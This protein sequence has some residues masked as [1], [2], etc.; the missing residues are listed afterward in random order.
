MINIY[1]KNNPF[2]ILSFILITSAISLN[3]QDA[4]NKFRNL[5]IKLHSGFHIY[6]GDKLGEALDN[7]YG[8]VEIRLGRTVPKNDNWTNY[9]NNPTYGFGVYSGAI[10]N[11]DLLGSP[12][13]IFGF[14]SFPIGKPDK[15]VFVIE[16]SFG[17]T[18]DLKPHDP[19]TNPLNDAIGSRAGVYFDLNFGGVLWVNREMDFTYGFD[20]SHFSNGRTFTPNYGLNM[21]GFNVGFRYHFNRTQ[22]KIDN[23][24]IPERILPSRPSKLPVLSDTLV[25]RHGVNLYA[26]VG[27]TQVNDLD[28]R[29]FNST[30]TVEY[31]YRRSMKHSYTF[32]FDLMYDGSLEGNYPE[33]KDRYLIGVHPGYDFSFWKLDLR[34]QVGFYLSDSRG[35]GAFYLRPAL[36]YRFNKNIFAQVGLKTKDGAAAD[37]VEYGIGVQLGK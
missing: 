11:P 31:A 26:A 17:I 20:L 32:G 4:Q 16:P 36:R 3:A 30:L 25:K 24:F 23:N 8:A 6:S 2:F 9:Y 10:G 5:E 34:A 18:Y 13:A 21:A 27:T 37:W 19:E 35:K 22:N 7:G 14:I 15:H 29:F 33:K 28:D 12:N 1:Q